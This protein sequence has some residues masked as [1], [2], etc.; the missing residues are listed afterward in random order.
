MQAPSPTPSHALVVKS[1]QLINAR[2]SLTVAEIRLFLMMVAQ[3]EKDD[4]DFKPYRIR[5]QDYAK[6]VGTQSK[7]HYK[8]IREAAQNLI[9]RIADIPRDDGGWLKVAFLSSAEYFKGEGM[10]ELGV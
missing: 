10:L 3:V 8:E 9:S 6:A 1:N 4:Q 2:Y 7:S 5:I